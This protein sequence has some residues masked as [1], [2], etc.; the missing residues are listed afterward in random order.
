[1]DRDAILSRLTETK[2]NELG[3]N[4]FLRMLQFGALPLLTLVTTQFPAIG[5]IVS[6]WLQPALQALR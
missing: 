3:K 2:A 5:R 6:S 4:F 1:M